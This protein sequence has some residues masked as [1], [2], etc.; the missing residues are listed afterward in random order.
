MWRLIVHLREVVSVG[1]DDVNVFILRDLVQQD[2]PVDRIAKRLPLPGRVTDA[3]STIVLN[4]DLVGSR[5]YIVGVQDVTY[6]LVRLQI[7]LLYTFVS[8]L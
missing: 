7:F 4:K 5:E 2:D 6:Q 8:T 1:T 3:H